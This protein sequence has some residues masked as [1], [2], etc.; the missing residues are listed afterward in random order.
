MRRFENIDHALG[1]AE[2][3]GQAL[4]VTGWVTQRDGT[5][6]DT[7]A[8]LFDCDPDRLKKTVDRLNGGIETLSAMQWRPGLPAYYIPIGSL[9]VDNAV[10][11]CHTRIIRKTEVRDDAA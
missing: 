5:R 10:K 1:Y 7:A 6:K 3:G 2:I 8:H 11:E 9:A 4:F